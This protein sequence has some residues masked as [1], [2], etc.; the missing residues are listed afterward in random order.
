MKRIASLAIA[1]AFVV[2]A[3]CGITIPGITTEAPRTTRAD[4]D[5]ACALFISLLGSDSVDGLII[6]VEATAELGNTKGES[7]Q[8]GLLACSEYLSGL[9]YDCNN[10]LLRV[11]D[12]VYGD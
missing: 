5:R 4:V 9:L 7:V 12:F 8:D 3:G 1:L 10:C 6:G 2:V 11:V